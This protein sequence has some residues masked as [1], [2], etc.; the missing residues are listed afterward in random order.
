MTLMVHAHATPIDASTGGPPDLPPVE[1][2][3]Y[4][5]ILE[6]ARRVFLARGFDAASMAEIA[7]AAAVSKGTLYV[8]FDNKIALFRALIDE[9]RRKT[10]E[11][12]TT[13]DPQDHDVAEVLYRFAVRLISELTDPAHVALVRMVIGAAEK[14]P[15]L[16]KALFESGPEFGATRLAEWLSVQVAKGTLDIDDPLIAAWHF[17]GMCNHPAMIGAVM[18][19][20]PQPD[21]ATTDRLARAAV[22]TF[23]RAHS[24][25]RA[26]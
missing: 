7:R 2:V 6:G 12:L 22:T 15:D 17:L 4:T 13:F 23:V 11:Q 21:S 20:I 1:S 19:S 8:Y 25:V 3:K 10:A 9:R 14:F 16:G 5:Q 24:P 26:I 18:A